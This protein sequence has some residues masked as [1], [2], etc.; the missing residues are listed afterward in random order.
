M[1]KFFRSVYQLTILYII[2]QTAFI[3]VQRRIN[4]HHRFIKKAYRQ[5][6][7]MFNSDDLSLKSFV[8]SV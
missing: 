6:K 2:L 7:E 5:A 8:D 3:I 4:D 1:I